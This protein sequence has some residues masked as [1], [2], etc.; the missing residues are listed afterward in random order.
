MVIKKSPGGKSA[1]GGRSTSTP[2]CVVP[3]REL[4]P[5][6]ILLFGSV[7]D[8]S[9]DRINWPLTPRDVYCFGMLAMVVF[10]SSFGAYVF[11]IGGLWGSSATSGS[12]RLSQISS[13]FPSLHNM[14]KK[15]LQ[16]LSLH[17]GSGLST[18]NASDHCLSCSS[19]AFG[20]VTCAIYS[21]SLNATS[22]WH[23]LWQGWSGKAIEAGCRPTVVWES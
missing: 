5:R 7:Q 2:I 12:C 23:D 3:V 19:R 20:C 16:M 10:E 9:G 18:N 8:A 1:G 21:R 13:T 6:R 14:A 11:V 22:Q 4:W 17:F 15:K